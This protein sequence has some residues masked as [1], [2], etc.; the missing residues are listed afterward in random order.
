M[1]TMTGRSILVRCSTCRTLNRVPPDKLS[2][3]PVC[4]QCKTP[5]EVPR[6]PVIATAGTFD[7]EVF[8]WPEY[9]LVEFWAKWCGYCRMVEPVINDLA[10]WR[11]GS[12]KVVRIDIDVEPGLARRFVVKATPTFILFKNGVQAGRLDGAPKEK[13]HLVQWVDQYIKQ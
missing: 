3:N 4:G 1:S 12:L 13:L 7:R 6:F 8:D 5:L 10:S 2:A 9:V 11:A